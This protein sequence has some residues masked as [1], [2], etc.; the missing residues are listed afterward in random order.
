MYLNL[1]CLRY[2]CNDLLAADGTEYETTI[3]K[4]TRQ[5]LMRPNISYHTKQC[6][7]KQQYNKTSTQ[8]NQPKWQLYM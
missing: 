5:Q 2:T 4:T 8:Q 3:R 6:Q 1:V 7:I